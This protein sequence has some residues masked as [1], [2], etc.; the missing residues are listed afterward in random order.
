MGV[1]I[2]WLC[3]WGLGRARRIIPMGLWLA[4]NSSPLFFLFFMSTATPISLYTLSSLHL[5]IRKTLNLHSPW[6]LEGEELEGGQRKMREEEKSF[7]L[8]VLQAF[9]K[10]IM[11]ARFYSRWV[12]IPI[13]SY[14]LDSLQLWDPNA[15]KS[16]P[17][18]L[19]LWRGDF[20][21]LEN[22]IRR[23]KCNSQPPP[24]RD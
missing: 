18:D 21:Y 12:P 16:K 5:S 3:E 8:D 9:I 15:C 11:E 23:P 19:N 13:Y 7:V 14:F 20:Y 4:H 2:W 1:T 6:K 10:S 24:S 17:P 22:N